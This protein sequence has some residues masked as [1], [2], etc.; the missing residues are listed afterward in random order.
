MNPPDLTN[1]TVVFRLTETTA[2]LESVRNTFQQLHLRESGTFSAVLVSDAGGILGGAR[3][4]NWS[5]VG[6]APSVVVFTNSDSDHDGIWVNTLVFE[7]RQ[8]GTVLAA[9]GGSWAKGT[10]RLI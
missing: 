6:R 3:V 7:S 1:C 5:E 9:N 4:G 10:F 2:D 8:G